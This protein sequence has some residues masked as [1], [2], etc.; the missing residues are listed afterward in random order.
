[1]AR[2]IYR[3]SRPISR[4]GAEQ[5]PFVTLANAFARRRMEQEEAEAARAEQARKMRAEQRAIESARR[6]EA[7]ERR[8]QEKHQRDK[9][10]WKAQD[11]EV[12]FGDEWLERRAAIGVAYRTGQIDQVQQVREL[13][14]LDEMVTESAREAGWSQKD[15]KL[16]LSRFGKLRDDQMEAVD[17]AVLEVEAGP[18]RREKQALELQ[19]KRQAVVNAGLERRNK[20]LSIEAK[21][22][23]ADEDAAKLARDQEA[24]AEELVRAQGKVQFNR[25]LLDLENQWAAGAVPVSLQEKSHAVQQLI[26]ES[27]EQIRVEG[28]SEK[29]VADFRLALQQ[30]AGGTYTQAQKEARTQAKA[31]AQ[32]ILAEEG[33]AWTRQV[34]AVGQSVVEADEGGTITELDAF[35]AQQDLRRRSA[36]GYSPTQEVEDDMVVV[37]A[38]LSHA[39]ANGRLLDMERDWRKGEDPQLAHPL[40]TSSENGRMPVPADLIEKAFSDQLRK[41]GEVRRANQERKRAADAK[42]KQDQQVLLR[43]GY[44]R[45]RRGENTVAVVKE[46]EDR[47][48]VGSTGAELVDM[49]NKVEGGGATIQN[50]RLRTDPDALAF[51]REAGEAMQRVDSDLAEL[52]WN[53]DDALQRGRISPEQHE[54]LVDIGYAAAEARMENAG[55]RDVKGLMEHH[56]L[57]RHLQT[58]GRDSISPTT[59]EGLS[60][61]NL[62]DGPRAEYQRFVRGMGF[63]LVSDG[64]FVPGSAEH[65]S[66]DVMTQAVLNHLILANPGQQMEQELFDRVRTGYRALKHTLSTQGMPQG[67]DAEKLFGMVTLFPGQEDV[68]RFEEGKID[69][70]ASD[71]AISSYAARYGMDAGQEAAL[72]LGLRQ[73]MDLVRE[74]GQVAKP[75]PIE[76][77]QPGEGGE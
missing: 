56:F 55:M 46:M 14:Q 45:I 38:M 6:A 60:Y 58:P 18:I 2:S 1:M 42:E 12:E 67:F 10:A 4:G 17:K 54:E 22:R 27:V 47:G 43:V 51:V 71:E 16:G 68:L 7:G 26:D 63:E 49:V 64:V 37:R 62:S 13:T 50:R 36:V 69:F 8:A 25:K 70:T 73:S 39:S 3:I 48:M 59:R 53:A 41:E 76:Y 24:D 28:A 74:L 15:I 65:K 32:R 19:A 52:R 23:K 57:D 11:F 34:A 29:G 61:L 21:L 72:L 66:A 5:S 30:T 31:E 44:D 33:E 20:Q 9:M 35:G 77:R 40:F 75:A